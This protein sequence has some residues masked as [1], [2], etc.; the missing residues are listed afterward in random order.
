MIRRPAQTFLLILTGS[1]VHGLTGSRAHA[2]GDIVDRVQAYYRSIKGYSAR[3]SEETRLPRSDVPFTRKGRVNVM[4]PSRMRWDYEDPDKSDIII[5]GR[6]LWL[7]N[8][9]RDEAISWAFAPD[10]VGPMGYAFLTGV[11]DFKKMFE[12]TPAMGKEGEWLILLM[13]KAETRTGPIQLYV[14]GDPPVLTGFEM[15]GSMGERVKIKLEGFA[16][17]KAF[18]VET[19]TYKP[20]PKTRIISLEEFLGGASLAPVSPRTAE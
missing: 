12:V 5:D 15:K 17:A 18:E 1:L 6:N 8:W 13:P 7:V 16:E 4:I 14:K 10:A 19:F 20:G 2:S 9:K 3:F 11:G